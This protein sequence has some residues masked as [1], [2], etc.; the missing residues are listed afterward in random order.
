MLNRPNVRIAWHV[1]GPATAM[2][3]SG[4]VVTMPGAVIKI[5]V[6]GSWFS[7]PVTMSYINKQLQGMRAEEPEADWQLEFRGENTDWRATPA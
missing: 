7:P 1:R 2:K 5:E 3:Q 4:V 6:A